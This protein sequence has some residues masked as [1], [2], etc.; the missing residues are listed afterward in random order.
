MATIRMQTALLLLVCALSLGLSPGQIAAQDSL[1]LA[2][3]SDRFQV[4][5]SDLDPPNADTPYVTVETQITI[6]GSLSN[7]EASISISVA[8]EESLYLQGY[9]VDPFQGALPAQTKLRILVNRASEVGSK[10]A[11]IRA[12]S[13]Q[14]SSAVEITLVLNRE[15]ITVS[16]LEPAEGETFKPGEYP[17]R[18]RVEPPVE[19]I[20]VHVDLFHKY[21]E[22]KTQEQIQGL[23]SGIRY[24]G[25]AVTKADGTFAI[26]PGTVAF[27]RG[28]GTMRADEIEGGVWYIHYYT[29]GQV[30]YG[31]SLDALDHDN[32]QQTV[33]GGVKTFDTEYDGVP[34]PPGSEVPESQ[35]RKFVLNAF[36]A[37]F[38]SIPALPE[39]TRPFLGLLPSEALPY[40][41]YVVLLMVLILAL[42]AVRVVA[43]AVRKKP[44]HR[45]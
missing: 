6:G 39:L 24:N 43:K 9:E 7:P 15:T 14:A 11:T 34:D 26:E 3:E 29:R 12:S 33:G 19:G 31:E 2:I 18:G 41:P 4:D 32:P 25:L 36:P 27:Q 23:K 35:V 37:W 42:V 44:E 17:I 13:G 22:L 20:I 45:E 30:L 16:I 1:T 10:K 28:F 40:A 8:G 5:L 38:E 21:P